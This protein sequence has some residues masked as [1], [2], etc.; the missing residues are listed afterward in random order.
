MTTSISIEEQKKH[1]LINGQAYVQFS[2]K[3]KIRKD[4]A[5]NQ[6]MY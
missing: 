1:G 6:E 2:Y 5:E 3:K 4:Y